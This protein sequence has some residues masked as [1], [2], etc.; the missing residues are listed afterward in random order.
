MSRKIVSIKN[1]RAGVLHTGLLWNF[2]VISSI[3]FSCHSKKSS[4]LNTKRSAQSGMD[5][6]TLVRLMGHSSPGVAARYY[7]HVTETHVTA[8][9]GKFVEYQTRN[10]AEGIP[11]A[12][13]D[14]S[15]AVQ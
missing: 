4:A 13:P 9:F 10:V 5:R 11:A 2:G 6:F 14:A 7:V 1:D 3:F 8:G 12:F 15:D